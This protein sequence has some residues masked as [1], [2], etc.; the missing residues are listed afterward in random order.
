MDS[1][2][3]C[4]ETVSPQLRKIYQAGLKEGWLESNEWSGIL[5][6]EG[7][8]PFDDQVTVESIVDDTQTDPSSY[9]IQVY[10]AE[11]RDRLKTLAPLLLESCLEVCDRLFM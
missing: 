8:N 11:N 2:I 9:T 5:M 1:N 3:I 6:V 10:P 7:Q 4:H